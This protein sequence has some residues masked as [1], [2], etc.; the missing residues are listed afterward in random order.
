MKYKNRF[1]K[2]IKIILIILAALWISLYLLT[3]MIYQHDELYNHPENNFSFGYSRYNSQGVEDAWNLREKSTDYYVENIRCC[4]I[5]EET[6]YLVSTDKEYVVLD[7]TSGE[8]I[9]YEASESITD[10]EH[11]KMF[12]FISNMHKVRG[13]LIG[14]YKPRTL[15]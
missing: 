1:K 12:D 15:I 14:K 8:F 5:D 9:L 4:Y 6:A 7:I 11:L 3:G 10:E 13:I 2:P